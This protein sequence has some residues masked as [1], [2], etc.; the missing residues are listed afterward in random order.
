MRLH[1]INI[2]GFSIMTIVLLV[3]MSVVYAQQGV[4]CF[5]HRVTDVAWSPDGERL[6]VLTLH[7]VLIYDH[8][9][10]FIRSI[11]APKVGYDRL[12]SVGPVWSPDGV[13]VILP[14]RSI[15]EV[16]A[17]GYEGWSIANTQTGELRGMVPPYGVERGS[18]NIVEELIWSPDNRLILA[19]K[20]EPQLGLQDP[21]S[22]LVMVLGVWD[23]GMSPVVQQYE[24]MHL[25]DIRWDAEDGITAQTEGLV[26][27]FNSDLTL[28]DTAPIPHANWWVPSPDGMREAAQ[29][30]DSNFVVREIGSEERRVGLQQYMNSGGESIA[31]GYVSEIIWLSDNERLIGVYRD[32]PHLDEEYPD[33]R[34]ILQGSIIDAHMAILVS[35]FV[36]QAD[37]EIQGHAVSVRGDRIAVVRD[38]TWVELWNPLTQERLV[39]LDIPPLPIAETC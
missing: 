24:N 12:T 6:A 10:N 25:S 32:I 30:P 33:L 23:V 3:T 18:S 16:A 21:S 31:I 14:Q 13:W 37:G 7:G 35:G 17:Q 19:L 27:S 8:D 15:P 1:R 29:K 4:Y 28:Q 36:L 9:L 26:L 5:L 38:D 11:E 34:T 39:T 20:Y 22:E 2:M